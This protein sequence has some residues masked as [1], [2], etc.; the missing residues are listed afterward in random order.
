[1]TLNWLLGN[2]LKLTILP[3][4]VGLESVLGPEIVTAGDTLN[5]VAPMA[6]APP[7]LIQAY[8]LSPSG[9]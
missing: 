2:I 8:V 7:F 1:M 3:H 4:V 6:N 9:L 5:A